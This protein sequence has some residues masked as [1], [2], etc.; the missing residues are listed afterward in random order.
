ML[1]QF[2]PLQKLVV[3]LCI[4][5]ALLA[6]GESF[7]F[8]QKYTGTDLEIRIKGARLQKDGYSAFFSLS[9]NIPGYQLTGVSVPPSV[10]LL[11]YPLTF[12]KYPQIRICW[13]VIQ[14]LLLFY[15][16]AFLALTLPERPAGKLRGVVCAVVFFIC[17]IYWMLHAER[18]QIYVLYAFLFCI[19]FQLFSKKEKLPVFFAGV[20]LALAIWF[21]VLFLVCVLPFLIQKNKLFLAGLF[22]GAF[23]CILVSLPFYHQWQDYYSAINAYTNESTIFTTHSPI[24][25]EGL[26]TNVT[27]PITY[28]DNFITGSIAYLN[29]YLLK[30]RVSLPQLFYQASYTFIIL[31]F[32][33]FKRTQI[34]QYTARQTCCFAF[35]LYIMFEYF[36][37]AARNPYNLI[38]WIFPVLLV[39]TKFKTWNYYYIFLLTGLCFLNAFPLHFP[40]C[41]ELG[42]A[43]IF[44]TIAWPFVFSGCKPAIGLVR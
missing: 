8:T 34:M 13:F 22:S 42:E 5:I 18:G 26:F 19:V 12:F 31:V 35:L 3:Y 30:L 4:F 1:Q 43:M 15:C 41:F 37:A 17:S 29:D 33:F 32:S 39:L 2:N 7:Y 23:F 11:H 20:V 27:F 14:Y 21:R 38:E 9:N 36:A 40:Y 25:K 16:I 28:K 44:T 6:L 24:A 10:L